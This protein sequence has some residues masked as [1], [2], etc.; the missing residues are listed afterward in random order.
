MAHLE[1]GLLEPLLQAAERG[2]VAVFTPLD[3]EVYG[4]KGA[5]ALLS[6]P[7]GQAGLSAQERDACARLLPWSR[8]VRAGRAVLEDGRSVDLLAY[9]EQAQNDLVLKPCFSSG[10]SGVTVGADPRVTPEAWRDA[11]QRAVDGCYVLQRLVRPTPDLFPAD[12]AGGPLPWNVVWGVFTMQGGYAGAFSRAVPAEVGDA[13]VNVAQ[14][15]FV[16]C[17]FHSTAGPV[18]VRRDA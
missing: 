15:A 5:L 2:E 7:A 4:S 13:V 17:C 8:R 10:G 9:A 14:G 16:G 12:A 1:D 11:L 18:E 3:A 6:D